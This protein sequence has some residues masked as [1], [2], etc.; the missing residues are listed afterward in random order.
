M[1]A[2]STCWNNSRHTDDEAMI[3]EIVNPLF[4]F[5]VRLSSVFSALSEKANF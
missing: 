2:F 3:G 1:L 5:P 4:P